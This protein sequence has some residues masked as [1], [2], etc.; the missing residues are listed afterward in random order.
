[1][2]S[3]FF[4][5]FVLVNFLSY[6]VMGNDKRK[7]QRGHYRTSEKTLWIMAI[8]GGATG[9]WVAMQ[10]YRH[11]TKHASFKYGMPVLAILELLLLVW[12]VN[13]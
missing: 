12:A 1:M 6:A 11:K 10:T 8:A 7:A 4:I 3:W 9:S 13:I 2:I 5:Y